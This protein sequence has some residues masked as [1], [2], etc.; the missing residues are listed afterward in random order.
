MRPTVFPPKLHSVAI[1]AHIPSCNVDAF[2]LSHHARRE[3]IA[4]LGV[5]QVQIR[6]FSFHVVY[7]CIRCEQSLDSVLELWDGWGHDYNIMW[8]INHRGTA[9][10]L[11]LNG[12]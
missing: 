7:E 4:N 2:Q 12:W 8:A 3:I 11:K 10:D 6:Q 9:R 1:I 5:P